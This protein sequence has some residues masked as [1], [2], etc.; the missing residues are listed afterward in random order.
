[1]SMPAS[2]L[3][4]RTP[5]YDLHVSLGAKMVPF[6]GYEMPVQYPAGIIG[7]RAIAESW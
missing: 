6:A 4:H 2:P 3:L 7:E 1:M 5:L